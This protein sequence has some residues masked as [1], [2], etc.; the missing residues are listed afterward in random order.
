VYPDGR[1]E[2]IR[3]ADIE[4]TPLTALAQILAAGDVLAVDNG[5]CGAESGLVPVSLASPSLLLARIEIARKAAEH[6]KLPALPP[7]G[8][9]EGGARWK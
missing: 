3:G 1:E 8:R 4:G 2:L 9:E 6:N 7:P 5:H